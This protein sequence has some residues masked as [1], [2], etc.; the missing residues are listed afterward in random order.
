MKSLITAI[1]LLALGPEVHAETSGTFTIGRSTV[2]SN[3]FA[4]TKEDAAVL[5]AN[6]VHDQ[7][8]ER[9]IENGMTRDYI[10]TGVCG[11]T[12]PLQIVPL[13]VSYDVRLETGKLLKVLMAA[14]D[15]PPDSGTNIYIIGPNIINGSGIEEIAAE[16]SV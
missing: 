12:G 16:G 3:A 7:G 13:A 6:L 4:C 10:E 11:V 15:W 2:I 14:T 1:V 9:A 8:A 5:I